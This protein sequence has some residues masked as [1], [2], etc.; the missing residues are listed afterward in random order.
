MGNSHLPLAMFYE[1]PNAWTAA[2]APQ[3]VLL[4]PDRQIRQYNARVAVLRDGEVVRRQTI[5]PNHP[6]H[7]AGYHVYLLSD[8]LGIEDLSGAHF[9]LVSDRGV[10]PAWIGYVLLGGGIAWCLWVR[11]GPYARRKGG[12]A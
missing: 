4:P 11:P 8:E 9:Q 2:G 1:D 3:I 12:A 10:W 7:Y 5:Q 6:M